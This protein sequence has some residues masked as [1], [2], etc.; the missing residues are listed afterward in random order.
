MSAVLQLGV[1]YPKFLHLVCKQ[2]RLSGKYTHRKKLSLIST[3]AYLTLV[4]AMTRKD[5]SFYL[6]FVGNSLEVLHLL[7][8]QKQTLS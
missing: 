3:Q 6:V 7:R 5:N 2:T 8:V 1:L 4:L